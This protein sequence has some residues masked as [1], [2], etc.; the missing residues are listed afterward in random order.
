MNFLNIV[1]LIAGLFNH[2][3]INPSSSILFTTSIAI[4]N[5][6]LGNGIYGSAKASLER[7]AKSIALEYSGKN[8]RCN[9][10]RL[11]YIKSDLS[12]KI[13]NHYIENSL[14]RYPLGI[15]DKEDVAQLC[16]FLLEAKSKW[17][18][19][20]TIIMDGGFSLV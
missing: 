15:G 14:E 17:I 9:C 12:E 2:K 10:I 1:R 18:T 7:F 13:G 5:I 16:I 11:G 4:E 8:I 19:G 3:R 20:Q 6:W